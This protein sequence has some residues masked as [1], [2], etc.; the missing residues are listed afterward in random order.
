MQH[1]HDEEPKPQEVCTHLE[2]EPPQ[3]WYYCIFSNS[4]TLVILLQVDLAS[5][6]EPKIVCE[7]C[8]EIKD[9]SIFAWS[10]ILNVGHYHWLCGPIRRPPPNN[11]ADY[12]VHTI[13]HILDFLQLWTITM[14]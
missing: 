1:L 3:A 12:L 9:T 11:K 7:G 4:R 6:D 14:A 8:Y 5:S 10:S 2:V 13:R